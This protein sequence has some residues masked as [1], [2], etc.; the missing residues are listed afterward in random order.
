M[1][2]V[3]ATDVPKKMYT[4][5]AAVKYVKDHF[6]WP[7]KFE[8]TPKTWRFFQ[9]VDEKKENYEIDVLHNG[10]GMVYCHVV[11]PF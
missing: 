8:E 4:F 2:K 9:K 3:F 7:Y 6:G 10:I 1:W 11:S 5:G